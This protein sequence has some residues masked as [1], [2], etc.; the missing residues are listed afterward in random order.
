MR[1]EED[2]A[3]RCDEQGHREQERPADAVVPGAEA[4]FAALTRMRGD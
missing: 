2:N 3:K 1:Q 4:A